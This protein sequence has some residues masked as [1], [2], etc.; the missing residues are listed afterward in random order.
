MSSARGAVPGAINYQG[1]LTGTNGSAV[2]G[3]VTVAVSVYTNQTGGSAVYEETVGAVPVTNGVYQFNWGAAGT[4]ALGPVL[5]SASSA[6]LEVN[7]NGDALTPRSQLVSVPYSHVANYANIAG[8]LDT[9]SVQNQNS[10]AISEAAL[11]AAAQAMAGFKVPST[12]VSYTEFLTGI[13]TGLYGSVIS[14]N[15][16]NV[17]SE[18]YA[19][20]VVR[21]VDSPA[22]VV[23]GSR[24]N[25]YAPGK[26]LRYVKMY[27]QSSSSSQYSPTASVAANITYEDTTT[28]ALTASITY[29]HYS[30][31][32]TNY[33]YLCPTKPG[34]KVTGISVNTIYESVYIYVELW[35]NDMHNVVYQIPSGFVE[36]GYEYKAVASYLTKEEGATASAYLY[37]NW[38]ATNILSSWVPMG[39]EQSGSRYLRY[40]IM[41]EISTN[42]TLFS[43]PNGIVL[44]KRT[45]Q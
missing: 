38:G 6:W 15:L 36:S 28:E 30:A 22:I 14:N 20:T 42:S 29:A 12:T 27:T 37:D 21:Q 2:N 3:N 10:E 7:M 45:I 40:E 31:G 11:V 4:P 1:Y 26:Y 43:K 35:Y 19:N 5:Q 41:P 24:N 16:H 33:K 8:S 17:G 25:V 9:A 13:S 34:L 23:D 39:G 18:Y 44:L 32:Q